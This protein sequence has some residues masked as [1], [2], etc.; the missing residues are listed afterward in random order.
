[1]KVAGKD[2]QKQFI[3][4]ENLWKVC[5][6]LS[7]PAVIAMVLYGL[8]TVFDAIFVGRFVGETALAGISLAY[9]LTMIALGLGS[10][11]G[12][13]AGSALSIALGAND[14]ETQKRLLGNLNCISLVIGLAYTGAAMFFAEPLVRM[15]GGQGEA[16]ILGT[17]YFRTAA[18]GAF[19]WIHGLACNMVV[20]AE[21]KMKTAA[22][23]MG[24]GLIVNI[25]ANYIFIVILN[26]GVKGAAWGTNIG[27]LTYTLLGL[28]YFSRK[29]VSFEARPFKVRKDKDIMK[30]IF[31]MGIPSLI[32]TVMTVIQ[33]IVI[34]NVLSRYGTTFDIAFYGVSFRI[35]TLLLTP[36]FGLM[37][38]LQPVTGI[39]FGAGENHRVIKGVKVFAVI[40]IV[41]MLPFYLFIMI[42][43]QTVLGTM[44]PNQVFS[45]TN[46]FNF[47]IFMALLPVLP[48]TFMGM[49]FFPAINNAKPA[50]IIGIV[51]QLI[52]YVPVMLIL[53]RLFGIQWVYWGSAGIDFVLTLWVV[54][55]LK[56]EFHALKMRRINAPTSN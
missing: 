56:K 7:W 28:A 33:G 27:M 10:L 49:T 54:F 45:V 50:A 44:L 4:S 32:M 36:V 30:S 34:F 18:I 51:R 9:P 13:G 43:P 8:N 11:I 19:F 20:R 1:M 6:Q 24:I 21:G 31:S 2:K 14:T 37:R 29:N 48:I 12:V 17:A 25:I 39:N 38:A 42:F 26:M 15:M 40:S 41:I 55:L 52:F 53:P 16:L 47:R 5:V 35:L 22:V 46:L 3:L 23:M